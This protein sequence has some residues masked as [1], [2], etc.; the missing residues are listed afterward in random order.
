MGMSLHRKVHEIGEQGPTAIRVELSRQRVSAK[1]LDDLDVDQLRRVQI[2]K[3]LK[4][5]RLD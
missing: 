5:P 3:T 4:E 2:L 1:H